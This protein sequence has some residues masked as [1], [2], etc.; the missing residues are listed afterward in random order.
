MP[1]ELGMT[2]ILLVE[3]EANQRLLYQMVL[4]D[5]GYGVVM[6]ENGKQALQ[7]VARARPDLVLLDLGMPDMDGI[8][9]LNRMMDLNPRMPVVIY[10]GHERLKDTFT[11]WAA[12]AY[13][14]KNSNPDILKREIGCVLQAR[15][16]AGLTPWGPRL[17]GSGSEWNGSGAE[18]KGSSI[19]SHNNG[20]P[21][22]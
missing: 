12:A 4:E 14:M 22:A 18:G 9:V 11:T 2:T 10:S 5:E 3:D 7:Q 20:T 16:M 21:S 19:N 17:L 15:E 13:V 1:K 8:T 6:A